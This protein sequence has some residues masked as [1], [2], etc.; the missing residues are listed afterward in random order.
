[1]QEEIFCFAQNEMLDGG[2]GGEAVRRPE[3]LDLYFRSVQATDDRL[4]AFTDSSVAEAFTVCQLLGTSWGAVQS[5][6]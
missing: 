6:K 2:A 1:M 3:G 5:G 4:L